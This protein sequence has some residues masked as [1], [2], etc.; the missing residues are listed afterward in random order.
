M[1]SA[2][3]SISTFDMLRKLAL[4]IFG[5][6]LAMVALEIVLRVLP[7]STYTDTGYHI[8]PLIITYRPHHRFRSSWGW[9][10][11]DPVEHRAN[12]LGFLSKRDF[13]P[14]NNALAVV[15]D[16]FVDASM[17]PESQRVATKLQTTLGGRPVYG[18]GGPGSSLLDYAE[19]I[20]YAADQLAVRDF[21]VILER[22][23]IKQSYCGSGNI[24]GPC[25]RRGTGQPDT[26][27]RGTPSTAQLYLR[28]CALLQYLL[29]HLRFDPVQRL[30]GALAALAQPAAHAATTPSGY[31]AAELALV[32][33]TFFARIAPYRRGQLVMVFDSDRGALNRGEPGS[34]VAR[35]EAIALARA[36]G[37]LVVDTEASF[38]AYLARSG[39]RLEISPLDQHWNPIATEIVARDIATALAAVASH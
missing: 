29:G 1:V 24:H 34:D 26:D 36:H 4:L 16:S 33:E 10:F 20:R 9:N 21:V 3:S 11:R 25:L 27:L 12:N 28:H 7:T 39:R 17:L 6:L 14:D 13:L 2:R 31:S 30:H 8:D 19:R 18:M 23:D 15:G 37:A 32:V 5:G 22:G 35:N 38:R